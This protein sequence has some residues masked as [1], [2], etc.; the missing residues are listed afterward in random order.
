MQFDTYNQI[1]V[2]QKY[3]IDCHRLLLY[4][5]VPEDYK[6]N[7]ITLFATHDLELAEPLKDT[8]SLYHFSDI[9]EKGKIVFDYKI[10][11]RNLSKTNAIRILEFN[12]YPQKVT[13]KASV[14]AA[15]IFNIK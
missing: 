2:C 14:L 8:F 15:Q 7:N 6:G 11:P 4:D 3:L 5:T 9:V 12:D 13:T 1:F 10:K